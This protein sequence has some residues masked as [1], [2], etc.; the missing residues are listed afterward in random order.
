MP[1]DRPRI[2]G[3]QD[4]MH[5]PERSKLGVLNTVAMRY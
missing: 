3:L 4:V 2:R 5:G 1:T